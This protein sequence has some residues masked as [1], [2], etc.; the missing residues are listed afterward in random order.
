[1]TVS[2]PDSS[3]LHHILLLCCV[4]SHSDDS[5]VHATA[6]LSACAL[7]QARPQNV[8]QSAWSTTQLNLLRTGKF[9]SLIVQGIVPKLTHE[10]SQVP[11]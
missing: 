5:H 3:R 7:A 6:S 11:K 10:L 1:M 4:Q 9:R 8:V 2:V